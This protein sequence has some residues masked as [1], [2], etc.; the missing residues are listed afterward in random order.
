MLNDQQ[1]FGLQNW[2]KRELKLDVTLTRTE[3]RGISYLTSGELKPTKRYWFDRFIASFVIHGRTD[4]VKD[5]E[6]FTHYYDLHV[7]YEHGDLTD[8]GSNGVNCD[9]FWDSQDS[10]WRTRKEAY[11]IEYAALQ[12]NS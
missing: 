2:I 1:V 7:R 3:Y 5:A 12:E 6:R 9:L 10:T 4:V 8:G 11:A